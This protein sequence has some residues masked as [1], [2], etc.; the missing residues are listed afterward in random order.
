MDAFRDHDDDGDG[1]GETYRREAV[2]QDAVAREAARL[3]ETGSVESIG[4]ALRQAAERLKYPAD[5]PLPGH[6]RVRKHAQMMAMQELGDDGYRAYTRGVL[7]IAEEVMTALETAFPD[8]RA[9]LVGRAADAK[10]DA[11]VTLYIR[12]STDE[13]TGVMAEL[14]VQFGYEEPT[15]DT[16]ETA[17]GRFSR[18]R[19][20]DD[21]Q[22][23]VITR[24]PPNARVPMD[25]DLYSQRSMPALDLVGVRRLISA[26]AE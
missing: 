2:Q 22:P 13:S 20:E 6:G 17:Y 1:D 7:T 8:L 25:V 23:V 21:G 11:G 16:A 4:S 3:I 15:F 14:L 5:Q 18:L 19:F 12:A 26:H 10:V 9:H 24:C